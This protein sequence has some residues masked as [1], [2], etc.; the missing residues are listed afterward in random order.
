MSERS[1]LLA[2]LEHST[3]VPA[4]LLP[5]ED[6]SRGNRRTVRDWLV[7]ALVFVVAVV[8]GSVI[9]ASTIDSAVHHVS[10]GDTVID[11]ALGAVACGL[12]WV[13]RRWP[14]GV[15]IATAALSAFSAVAAPA[16][17][18]AL[19]TVAVHRRTSIALSIAI[20]GLVPGLVFAAWRPQKDG[21]WFQ[22]GLGAAIAA[23]FVAW[24]MF[25]RG[26]R[27][28]VWTLRARAERA[29]NEQRMLAE[30]ARVAERTR[31]AREMHDVLGHRISLIALSAGALELRPDVPQEQVR[32]SAALLRSTARQALEELRD[33]IGVLRGDDV[34]DALATPQPTLSDLP[35]LIE[36]TQDAGAKIDF[37]MAVDSETPTALGR[38]AYRIVQ[39][40]LTNVAKHAPGTLATVRVAGAPGDELR[41]CV[42]NRA[43]VDPAGA[44]PLP[45]SGSGLIGLLERVTLAGGTLVHGPDASG[46]F[47][48]EASLPWR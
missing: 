41:V 35:R 10:D 19:F 48:V 11:W 8:G 12:L 26:R 15:A 18:I 17:V 1:P 21:L 40:A 32:A 14:V 7:D 23:A 43:S 45:G 25:V 38:D 16:S 37:T 22:L 5:P 27:Q 2:R 33:V 29:E 9:F 42:R 39:E 6:P 28:L 13:R 34:P 36:Q 44:S 20:G 47:V 4:S 3:L 24:G 30:Q 46:D 31:I